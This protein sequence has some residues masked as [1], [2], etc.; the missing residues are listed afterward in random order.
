LLATKGNL[1]RARLAAPAIELARE[2]YAWAQVCTALSLES[3]ELVRQ[4]NQSGTVYFP[5]WEAIAAGQLMRLPK[6]AALIEEWVI[7]GS[8]LF[9]D[10]IG[11][12]VCRSVA[13]RGGVIEAPDL[14]NARAEWVD[15][16]TGTVGSHRLWATPAPTH[17]VSLIEGMSKAERGDDAG[18]VWDRVHQ[19]IEQRSLTLG[20]SGTSMVSAADRAGNVVVLIHSNSFPRFG[21]GLVVNEFELILNN[22]AGRGFSSQPGHPNFPVGGRRPATTLHAW[23]IS[24]QQAS[25]Q[26]IGGTPGGENQM[27]W[28]AQTLQQIIDGEDEPGRLVVAPR[29]EI[30]ANGGLAVEEGF[31]REVMVGLEKRTDHIAK[32]PQW[33][34]SSAQQVILRPR[35]GSAIVGAVDPRTGGAAV[36]V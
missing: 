10:R 13:E 17:G 8:E 31:P 23:A 1:G 2:G 14:R 33:S 21:S 25:A 3:L 20:D 32:V 4:H 18:T 22:R 35:E 5:N 6:L 29:W 19:S 11:D 30:L 28:N 16:A 9:W 36:A 24:D 12:V 26:F 15:P 7:V 34:L 27:P